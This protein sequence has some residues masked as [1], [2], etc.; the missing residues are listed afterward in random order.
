[1]YLLLSVVQSDLIA[2]KEFHDE[3]ARCPPPDRAAEWSK[4]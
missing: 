4:L 1:M 3:Q 2:R